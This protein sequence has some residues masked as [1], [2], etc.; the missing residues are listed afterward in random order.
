MAYPALLSA[1]LVY[2]VNFRSQE[3]R[4]H[5][6]PNRVRFG[7]ATDAAATTIAGH[8][9][10]DVSGQQTSLVKRI[11]EH[12][13][14]GVHPAGTLYSLHV[15]MRDS[16]GAVW[17]VLSRNWISTNPTDY[18]VAL[19]TGVASADAKIVALSAPPT[20]PNSGNPVS[21]IVYT[22]VNRS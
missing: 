8:I 6:R 17:R 20:L 1:P 16:S 19:Y 18:P 4:Q 3:L 10:A 12:N 13:L 7:A 11:G 9:A 21:S 5:G 14:L 2:G 15:L 22:V